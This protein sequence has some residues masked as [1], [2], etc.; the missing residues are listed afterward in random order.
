MAAGGLLST[1]LTPNE[2][3]VDA[4]CGLVLDAAGLRG[5]SIV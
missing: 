1:G 4:L 5:G 2:A 3:F